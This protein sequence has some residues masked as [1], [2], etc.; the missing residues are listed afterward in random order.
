M[1]EICSK[2]IIKKL[3]QRK[4]RRS[5]VIIVDFEHIFTLLKCFYE[6]KEVIV[7]FGWFSMA[8]HYDPKSCMTLF[9]S[10]E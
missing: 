6:F 8:K 4:W 2:L 7:F 5:R 3:T 10:K 1:G 9:K